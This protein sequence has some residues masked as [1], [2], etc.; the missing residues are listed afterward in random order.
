MTI[1]VCE[2]CGHEVDYDELPTEIIDCEECGEP[3]TGMED[4]D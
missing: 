1:F 4:D 3:M 2:A